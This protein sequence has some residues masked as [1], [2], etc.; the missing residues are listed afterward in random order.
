M[1]I[2]EI[3][4]NN[5]SVRQ[6]KV[7]ARQAKFANK[8]VYAEADKFFTDN[9]MK[10]NLLSLMPKSVQTVDKLASSIGEIQNI[11]I[12][13]IGTGLIAPIF[14]KYNPLSKTDNDTKT[15]TA[16]RQPVSAAI[17]VVTQATIVDRFNKFISNMTNSGKFTDKRYDKSG[18]QDEKY[19]AE[20]LKKQYPNEG[21]DAIAARVKE[22]RKT[23]LQNLMN[24][25]RR[26]NTIQ[27]VSD[28]KVV[29]L[30][31]EDF[32]VVLD[33][34][35]KDMMK[36]VEANLKRYKEIKPAMKIDRAVYLR[37]NGNEVKLTLEKL[38]E[39]ITQLKTE[40]EV[41]KLL[42]SKVQQLES[43]NTHKELIGIFNDIK[44]RPSK[45]LVLDKI[46]HNIEKV[47]NFA[48]CKTDEEVVKKIQD[49]LD[50]K[51]NKFEAEKIQI[52]KLQSSI[53]GKINIRKLERIVK[54]TSPD[55]V[56]NVVQKHIDRVSKSIN[57]FKQKTGLLISLAIL[58]VSCA[59]LNYVYPKIM[60]ALFPNLSKT[61]KS[62]EKDKFVKSSVETQTQAETVK[63]KN[64]QEVSK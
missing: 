53:N 55:F 45:E 49:M 36:H 37:N 58:P 50:V 33:S 32:K 62:K 4:K 23:Q 2:G 7:L 57:G 41:A 13:A 54:D 51:I 59:I 28:G 3:A 19:I 15:Y 29:S 5:F 27:Y 9:E 63:D 35:A 39:E 17:A 10:K 11:I 30:N 21:K 52:Q 42:K 6:A 43:S 20:Q 60:D 22:L 56:Y 46:K 40:K 47:G 25:A 16:L 1:Q 24:S 64:T 48:N 34:T 8:G 26:H 38:H 61:K 31:P 18:F 44:G 12:T 14:I